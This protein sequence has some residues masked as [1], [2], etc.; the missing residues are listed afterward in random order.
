MQD[1]LPR[2][3]QADLA[4]FYS[5][6][7]LA[8]L[9]ELRLHEDVIEG[10]VFTDW[11]E[12]LDCTEKATSNLVAYEA[13]R[14]FALTLAA[15]FERQ[16][17]MWARAHSPDAHKAGISDAP[18]D[19]LLRKTAAA[20]AVDLEGGAVG[21]TI[22][23]LHL[24]ANAVRH[25]DGRSAGKLESVAPHLWPGRA[26]GVAPLADQSVRSALSDGIQISDGDFDRYIRALTRFW[27]LADREQ[28]AQTD[29]YFQG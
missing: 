4:R 8:T 19:N 12:F 13:R 2:T 18:F 7:I 10:R 11:E 22:A 27:G 25:G 15:L 28:G 29:L 9:S 26:E 14:S 17:R 16:L 6:V 1:V 3:F 21:R 23:E 24:L 20:H 5:R